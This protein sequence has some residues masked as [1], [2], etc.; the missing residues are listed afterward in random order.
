MQLHVQLLTQSYQ[1]ASLGWGQELRVQN[2]RMRSILLNQ[3]STCGISFLVPAVMYQLRR[4]L[5]VHVLLPL[6]SAVFVSWLITFSFECYHRGSHTGSLVHPTDNQ[7]P[8]PGATDKNLFWFLQV[9]CNN[10]IAIPT[11]KYTVSTIFCNIL[12]IFSGI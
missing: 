11:H 1:Y 12:T 9:L 7:T 8:Y 10:P 4:L 3:H 6:F 2:W 5:R